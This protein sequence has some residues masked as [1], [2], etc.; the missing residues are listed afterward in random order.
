MSAE[1]AEAAVIG[2]LV[3]RSQAI[4]EVEF[5]KPDMF[6]NPVY[7]D[8]F[9]CFKE[10]SAKHEKFDAVTVASRMSSGNNNYKAD[11]LMGTFA[12]LTSQSLVSTN[13]RSY[14]KIVYDSY[15]ARE[16]MAATYHFSTSAEKLDEDIDALAATLDRL[17]STIDDNGKTIS[18]IA[19]EVSG[20]YFIPRE[21]ELLEFGISNIDDWCGGM[22]GGDLIVIAARPAVGK[23]AFALQAMQQFTAQGR[24]VAYFNLEMMQKQVFER[25]VASASGIEMNAIRKSTQF[26]G[27]QKQLYQSGVSELMNQTNITVYQGAWSVGKIRSVQAR[28]KF[29]VI[30]I[31]YLQLLVPDGKRA[32]NRAAEVGDIS[33]G[34]KNIAV[35]F[36]VPVIALSQL[37]R[38]SEA[39]KDREPSMTELR[40]SGA[41][42]QDASIILMLW[43]SDVSDNAKRGIK[44][45]KARQGTRGKIDTYFDGRYMTF[46][47]FKR[48]RSSK[49]DDFKQ[50]DNGMDDIPFD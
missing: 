22:D 39:N 6:Q 16:L 9:T 27:N 11:N 18:E 43:Q 30:V 8:I 23:S 13:I 7:K 24:R 33:R 12:E 47:C 46:D 31:D 26:H 25:A 29:D 49:K 35:D 48:L 15:R 10:L 21:K 5:L 37:N 14:A 36:N 20:E 42:E 1:N 40:E 45:E 2:S 44:V 41:I 34:L 32:G 50:M 3:I 28:K 19:Q 38:A 17:R 4:E